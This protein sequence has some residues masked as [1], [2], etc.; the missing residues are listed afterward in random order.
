MN[1]FE[2][3]LYYAGSLLIIALVGVRIFHLVDPGWAMIGVLLGTVLITNAYSRYA[4][5][6]AQ[7]NQELEEQLGLTDTMPEEE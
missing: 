3:T 1:S 7:R 5:R 4:R 2:K 6:L